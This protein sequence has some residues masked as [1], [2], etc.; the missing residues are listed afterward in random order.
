LVKWIDWVRLSTL[1]IFLQKLCVDLSIMVNYNCKGYIIRR[2]EQLMDKLTTGE[3][4]LFLLSDCLKYYPEICQLTMK[5]RIEGQKSV[6]EG[7][8]KQ[9]VAQLEEYVSQDDVVKIRQSLR[10][11]WKFTHKVIDL[12][13]PSYTCDYCQHQ[14]I[15]YQYL[16]VN[17]VNK[18]WLKL[19]SSCVGK[20]I[21]GEEAMNNEEFADNFV[22][23]LD[24]LKNKAVKDD[25][26]VKQ[27]QNNQQQ[28]K[29]DQT[30]LR[31]IEEI[32]QLRLQQH[33][34]IK[35]HTAYLKQKFPRSE[36]LQSLQQRWSEGRLLTENQEKA[37]INWSTREQDKEKFKQQQNKEK[38]DKKNS[39]FDLFCDNCG[40]PTHFTTYG[41]CQKCLDEG[42]LST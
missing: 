39:D 10:K 28:N 11:E 1:R 23:G 21:H 40:N 9:E 31:S 42:G 3:W 2:G 38:E 32:R 25:K 8:N 27:E 17:E 24:K 12:G 33:L 34:R 16:C 18:K 37:L 35:D 26:E 36:F 4:R 19:G 22:K 13:E 20:I 15:R 14:I 30:K 5:L 29:E 41:V 7:V 6:L